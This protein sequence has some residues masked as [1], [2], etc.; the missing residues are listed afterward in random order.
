VTVHCGID[1][2]SNYAP[3]EEMVLLLL[4]VTQANPMEHKYEGCT[5]PMASQY[6][7]EC[8]YQSGRGFSIFVPAA[9]VSYC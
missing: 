9:N 4:P 3:G 1:R 6:A 7:N 8:P 5:V 2:E